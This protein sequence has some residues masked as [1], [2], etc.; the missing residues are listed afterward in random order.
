VEFDFHWIKGQQ[1]LRHI[2]RYGTSTM[3]SPANQSAVLWSIMKEFGVSV[4]A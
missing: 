3:K 2:R 1:A 4:F